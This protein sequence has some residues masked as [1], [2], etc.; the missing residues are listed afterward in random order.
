MGEKSEERI[1]PG[2]AAGACYY[3]RTERSEVIFAMFCGCRCLQRRATVVNTAS[4]IRAGRRPA[5]ILC[6][7]FARSVINSA[8]SRAASPFS[9][10]AVYIWL[11]MAPE[12]TSGIRSH[13]TI[14]P[15]Y[16]ERISSWVWT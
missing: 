12:I 16:R 8:N 11:P 13:M 14:C 6:I 9:A 7:Y 15:P 4:K 2:I 10:L 3:F 5:L 1:C